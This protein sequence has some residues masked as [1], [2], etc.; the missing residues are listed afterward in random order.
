[1]SDFSP[2][3]RRMDQDP[4]IQQALGVLKGASDRYQAQVALNLIMIVI[5]H[6]IEA[7]TLHSVDDLVDV[8]E[9]SRKAD[10]S[11]LRRWYDVNET[12]RAA[13][14]L[15]EECPEDVQA[16]IIPSIQIMVENSLEKCHD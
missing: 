13:L 2:Q 16:K 10:S 7:S 15:L 1:M 4:A 14:K 6:W 3:Q 8:L 12:M 11:Q 9:K 5:E